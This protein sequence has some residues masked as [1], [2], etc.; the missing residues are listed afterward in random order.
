MI[1]PWEEIINTAII[2]TDK[3]KINVSVLAEELRQ[4]V[5][6]I[7]TSADDKDLIFLHISSVVSNYRKG[8]YLPFPISGNPIEE[9]PKEDKKYCSPAAIHALQST[10]DDENRSLLFYW[11]NKCHEHSL[12]VTPEYIPLLFEKT[13]K[14]SSLKNLVV[15]CCGVRGQWMTQ[16]NPKWTFQP[17]EAPVQEVFDHGKLEERKE[18]LRIWRTSNP[19]EARLALEKTWPQEQAATKTELL[20]ALKVNLQLTDEDFL[21]TCL[22]E[23]SQK[24]KEAAFNLLKQLPGSFIIKEV[25]AFLNPLMVYKKSSAILGLLNKETIDINLSFQIPEHFKT[26]GISDIDANE[27]YNEKEFT[28]SQLISI[29][30]LNYWEE[31]FN[32]TGE[33]IISLFGKKETTKKFLPSFAE[34]VNQYHN[35][36]W[37][38]VL[39]AK[40]DLVCLAVVKAFDEEMQQQILLSNLESY[41]DI[42][43]ILADR[44]KEW[45]IN[46]AIEFIKKT[47]QEPYIYSKAFYKNI[48][49]HLPISLSDKLNQIN[50]EEELKQQ[51]WVNLREDM[52]RMLAIKQQINQ[53]F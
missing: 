37:A 5:E 20:G 48:I 16:F 29:I 15:S 36:H 6:H 22:K 51:Y 1:K 52:K 39:Y 24:V 9:C 23:K 25:W 45:N 8:G 26:Y 14:D 17:T 12:L 42:Y 28:L 13:E 4:T 7:E 43:Q 21:K 31:H 19:E 49:H 38:K 35:I 32:L 40:H 3:R 30:P 50:Q 47:A 11:L 10:I 27:M 44:N 18:A 41:R 34:A 53:S 33:E 46:F 2:G